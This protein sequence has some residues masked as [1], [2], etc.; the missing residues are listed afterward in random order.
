MGDF[1][2]GNVGDRGDAQAKNC[3]HFWARVAF[4]LLLG[5]VSI[6]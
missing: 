3:A 4:Y 5:E 1:S 6:G 2:V